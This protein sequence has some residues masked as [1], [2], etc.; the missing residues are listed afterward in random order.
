MTQEVTGQGTTGRCLELGV[1]LE[2]PL[3]RQL[4]WA[5]ERSADLTALPFPRRE[6]YRGGQVS[7]EPPVPPLGKENP[8]GQ[9]APPARRDTWWEPPL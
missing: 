6:M 3:H 1:S 2:R 4:H 7:P 9:P 8:G 5:G